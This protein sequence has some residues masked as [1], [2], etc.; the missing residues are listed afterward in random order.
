MDLTPSTTWAPPPDWARVVTIDSHTA[1]EPFRVVV[2]GTPPIP[3]AT[4]IERRRFAQEHLDVLRRALMWEPRGHADMYGG[5]IGSPTDPS[6]DLSVLF[7]HNEGFSTMCGHGIIALT[8]VVLDTGIL[9]RTE[10]ETV[11]RIDT[12]AGQ[13][14]ATAT[15]ADGVVGNVRFRNVPSFVVDLD[16]TVEVPG[17]GPVRYD[18]AFGGAFYAYV[19][20]ADLGIPLLPAATNLLIEAGRAIKE[21]VIGSRTIPHPGEPDLGFL[22][23]VIFVGPAEDPAHHSRNVCV[24][25]E[26]E[27]DRS[28]TGTGVSGWLAI[29]HARGELGVGDTVT[30]ESIVGST[31]TGTV[32]ETT[33][34]EGLAAVIPEVA[35]TAHITGRNELWLDPDDVLGAGFLLR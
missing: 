4:M 31:F 23:G 24:F 9:P 11:I 3:G 26:A 28:P 5:L 6:S 2:G 1:G 15:V 34:F 30:I 29:H 14:V 32:I 21:A 12:P 13:I 20:A 10:P 27:V 7:I 25:A 17:L 16:N 33:E 18:L 8:K 19:H 22:Y 35:G